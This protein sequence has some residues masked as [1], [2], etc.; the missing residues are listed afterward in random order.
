MP[1]YMLDSP[2]R[3]C[4]PE[5]EFLLVNSHT[6][7]EMHSYR[8][9]ALGFLPNYPCISKIM[10]ALGLESEQRHESLVTTAKCLGLEKKLRAQE[11]CPDLLAKL[12]SQFFFVTSEEISRLTLNQVLMTAL[13]SWFFYQ[14]MLD[15]CG[16]PELNGLLQDLVDQQRN[17]YRTLEEVQRTWNDKMA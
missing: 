12:R 9:F 10:V 17:V 6:I 14:L 4:L 2:F 1:N 15:S 8:G 13:N 3:C 5:E 16:T 7:E 11:V